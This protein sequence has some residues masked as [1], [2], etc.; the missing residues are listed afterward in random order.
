MQSDNCVKEKLFG[1]TI[2]ISPG[3]TNKRKK[4]GKRE[5][6]IKELPK[7]WDVVF[8]ENWPNGTQWPVIQAVQNQFVQITKQYLRLKANIFVYS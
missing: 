2:L 4:M 8:C 6:I 1:C 3:L 7:N 5:D